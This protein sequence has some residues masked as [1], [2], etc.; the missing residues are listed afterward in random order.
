[1]KFHY[2]QVERLKNRYIK[3]EQAK[4]HRS[5][6]ETN[7]SFC[8]TPAR[9][10]NVNEDKNDIELAKVLKGKIREDAI[11]LEQMRS[12]AKNKEVNLIL[13]SYLIL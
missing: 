4:S 8:K 6:Q 9:N 5:H 10:R 2:R 13:L 7:Q 1:M 11:L 3:L 12:Q